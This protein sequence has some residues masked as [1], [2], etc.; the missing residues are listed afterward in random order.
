MCLPGIIHSEILSGIFST[1]S[2][3]LYSFSNK[4]TSLK[5]ADNSNYSN[6]LY[7][8]GQGSQILSMSTG[9]L[10]VQA[11]KQPAAWALSPLSVSLGTAQGDISTGC[12][13]LKSG[14]S[15]FC[16]MSR[17]NILSCLLTQCKALNSHSLSLADSNKGLC[18]AL[19][20]F[21]EKGC[22]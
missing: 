11:E 9:S 2:C 20:N 10:R 6:R 1:G 19:D 7:T 15:L 14:Q 13:M 17:I 22:C 5:K 8:R 12:S 16:H 18:Q 4:Q 21:L 3:C